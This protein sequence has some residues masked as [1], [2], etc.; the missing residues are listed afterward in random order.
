M[1]DPY[2]ILGVSP[3]ASDEEVKRAYRDLARKYHPD[4]YAENPLSDL[5]EE[6][7]KEINE[8]YDEVMRRRAQGGSGQSGTSAGRSGQGNSRSGSS[9]SSWGGS[10]GSG[11]LA[12]ARRC[13]A[14]GNLQ[15]AEEI[16]NATSD[17]SAEW[18]FLMGS[19]A[20]RKGWF[21]EATRYY[22][23]A[24]SMD[25]GNLEYRQAVNTMRGGASSYYRQAPGGGSSTCDCCSSLIC[26]DCCCEC[27]GG[28]LIPCIGC[29]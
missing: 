2:K 4:K 29:R 7:M 16:L 13:L 12:E 15:R 17:H 22:E 21:D 23:T 26:A 19:L 1:A 11:V 8:A 6:K 18:Y 5:A 9:G 24:A 25:P 20:Y 27:M 3:G 14:S 28:N 10:G